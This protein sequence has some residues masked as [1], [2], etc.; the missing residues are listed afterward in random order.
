MAR[1]RKARGRRAARLRVRDPRVEHHRVRD[2]R[3]EHRRARDQMVI[4]PEKGVPGLSETGNFSLKYW[5]SRK[6]SVI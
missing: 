2:P 1:H 6:R 3:V 4:R 5:G